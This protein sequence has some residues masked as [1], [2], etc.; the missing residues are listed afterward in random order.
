MLDRIKWVTKRLT[1][2]ILLGMILFLVPWS[3]AKVYQ[4]TG[5]L[6]WV[7]SLYQSH[8]GA[9]FWAAF[10]ISRFVFGGIWALIIWE[11]FVEGEKHGFLWFK[12]EKHYHSS[13][14]DEPNIDISLKIIGVV[15]F[16]F[17]AV[18]LAEGALRIYTNT[19]IVWMTS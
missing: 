17:F 19:P 11:T 18:V 6:A 16:L 7:D 4:V 13:L 1:M 2:L 3:L 14:D 8:P 12:P 9:G 10:V 15:L 5:I